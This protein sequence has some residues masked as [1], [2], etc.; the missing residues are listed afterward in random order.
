MQRTFWTAVAALVGLGLSAADVAN[1]IKVD[2]GSI[3]GPVKPVNGVGLYGVTDF[4]LED[5][6]VVETGGDGLYVCCNR[7]TDV[8]SRDVTVRNCVFDRSLVRAGGSVRWKAFLDK[9]PPHETS[10][11]AHECP[12]CRTTRS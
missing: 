6:S 5:M 8:P 3:I 10:V 1:E 11:S 7:G 12:K 9:R 2:F 4:T